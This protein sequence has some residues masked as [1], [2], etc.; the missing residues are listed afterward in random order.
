VQPG[1][2]NVNAGPFTNLQHYFY[3]FG[4]EYEYA[5]D[6]LADS[7]TYCAPPMS[8]VWDFVVG[9]GDQ[10][11]YPKTIQFYAWAVRDGNVATPEPTTFALLSLGLVGVAA[12]RRRRLS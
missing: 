10:T 12:S 7:P 11:I 3:W 5:P 9:Y 6:N 1:Y 4:T 8:C 2:D